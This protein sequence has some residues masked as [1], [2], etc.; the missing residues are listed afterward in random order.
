M[1]KFIQKSKYLD[2]AIVYLIFISG[3]FV[4]YISGAGLIVYNLIVLLPTLIFLLYKNSVSSKKVL[5][6]GMVLGFLAEVLFD[7]FAHTSKAWFSP[8][9]LNFRIFDA[10]LDNLMWTMLFVTLVIAFYEH[11]FDHH[12]TTKLP[13]HIKITLLVILIVSI[14]V[15]IVYI[16]YPSLFQISYFY[17]VAIFAMVL[18]ELFMLKKNKPI[19]TSA[20]MMSILL[21]PLAFIHEIT[22][23]TNVH[24]LFEIGYHIAYVPLVGFQIPIEEILFFIVGPITIVILYELLIDNGRS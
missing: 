14:T 5:I 8:T 6:Y 17:A 16:L 22:S 12:K 10:P 24:W 4:T 3:S 21:L 2:L 9:I 13:S 11:F 23:I 19:V 20:L 7:I 1:N 18:L 15:P